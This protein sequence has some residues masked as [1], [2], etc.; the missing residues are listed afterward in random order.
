MY[1]VLCILWPVLSTLQESRAGGTFR[2]LEPIV[3]YLLTFRWLEPIV[4]Y[5]L[6]FLCLEAP[7]ILCQQPSGIDGTRRKR[8]TVQTTQGNI[9]PLADMGTP[10]M[11]WKGE[12][13]IDY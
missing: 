8:L 3:L 13:N 2:W 9:A 10:E 11:N 5:L 6:T 4:L 12:R 1:V 7:D